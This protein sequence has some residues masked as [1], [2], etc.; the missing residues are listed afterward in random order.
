MRV[1]AID[2]HIMYLTGGKY[3]LRASKVL[4]GPEK[5]YELRK[6][7]ALSEAAVREATL[8]GVLWALKSVPGKTYVL[9]KGT[10]YAGT[11]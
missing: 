7:Y 9:Y 1:L 11:C 10:R 4:T 3:V 6:L 2:V 8:Y 5:K